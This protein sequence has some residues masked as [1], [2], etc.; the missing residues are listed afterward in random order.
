MTSVV[1]V[2]EWKVCGY[3]AYG[4]RSLFMALEVELYELFY[5]V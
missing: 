4:H 1:R 3:T 5:I 2:R